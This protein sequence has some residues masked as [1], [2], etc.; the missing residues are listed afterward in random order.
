MREGGFVGWF[1]RGPL[2]ESLFSSSE[3]FSFVAESTRPDL[4][5]RMTVVF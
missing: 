4:P 3:E 1:G 2:K 5:C